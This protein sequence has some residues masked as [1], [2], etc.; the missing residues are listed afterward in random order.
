M[1]V[2]TALMTFVTSAALGALAGGVLAAA[3][4]A[5]PARCD[6]DQAGERSCGPEVP[7]P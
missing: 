4:C 2:M 1:I 3:L 5:T 6:G 7:T